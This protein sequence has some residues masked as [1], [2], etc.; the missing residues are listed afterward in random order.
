M[1]RAWLETFAWPSS[2]LECQVK[3][4]KPR[5]QRRLR[6]KVKAIANRAGLSGRHGQAIAPQSGSDQVD[7]NVDVAARG[8]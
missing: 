1:Q 6:S 7:A 2:N 3:I 5:L 4:R 8:L